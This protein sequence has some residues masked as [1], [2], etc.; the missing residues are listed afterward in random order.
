MPPNNSLPPRYQPPQPAR[1]PKKIMDIGRPED[2]PVMGRTMSPHANAYFQNKGLNQQPAPLKKS[3][4]RWKKIAKRSALLLVVLVVLSAGWVGYKFY[5][6]FRGYGGIFSIFQSTKLKG[7]DTGR[8]NILLAGNS[9]DDPGHDGADLTD[10]IMLVSLDTKNNT[11]FMFSVPRDLY[12]SL[13]NGADPDYTGHGKINQAIL[14]SKFSQAGYPNGG[15]GDLEQVISQNLGIPIDYYALIDYTAFRDAVNAI[16]GITINIQ[17]C[18]PYG[19]YD[20]DR[21]YETGGILVNLSNGEHALNGEQALDLA[22]ARGDAYGSYGFC[23]SDF[24]RTADQRLMLAALEKK[25]LSAGVLANPIK[26][27]NLFDSIGKNVQTDLT[28]SDMREL[29]SLSKKVSSNKIQSLTLSESGT[30]PLLTNYTTPLGQDALI[31]TA[32]LDNFSDI[33][34]YM[35]QITAVSTGSSSTLTQ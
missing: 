23:Q 35:Q 29:Y 2:F 25:A 27:G 17:S 7:E 18:S 6:D 34:A 24:T 33:Q 5:K 4:K 31:P 14:A 30:S 20:P 8:I 11:G 1:P 28:L 26:L 9:A 32:G 10:S 22:R 12:V 3:G 15:M 21:D 19:L 13:P 16:G